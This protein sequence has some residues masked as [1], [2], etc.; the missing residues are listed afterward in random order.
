[1][2]ETVDTPMEVDKDIMNNDIERQANIRPTPT[3]Y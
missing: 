3:H 2:A 1:M